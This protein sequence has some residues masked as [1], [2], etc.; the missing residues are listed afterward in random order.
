MT[1]QYL[2]L[3]WRTKRLPMH[4]LKTTD[5]K[6]VRILHIGTYNT[7]SG[8]DF[9]NGKIEIDGLVHSGNIEMHLKSSD[10][11][12]HGHQD[13]EAYNNVIL[14]VVYEYDRLVFIE[15][16]P[17]P[18]VEL[19]ELIDQEHLRRTV[20]LTHAPTVIP[21]AGQLRDCPEPVIWNQVEQALFRRLERK[22]LELTLIAAQVQSDPRKVLFHAIAAAFGMR[23][24][25]LPFQELAHRLPLER[26]IRAGR[27]QVES[28]VFGV[29][30]LLPEEQSDEF[31]L[32]LAREW[33]FQQSKYDLHSAQSHAWQFKG[34]R[35]PG[36]PTIRLAQ[37]SAFVH[38][39]D[40]TESFWELPVS[41]L[42][43]QMEDLLMS[44]PNAYWKNH[45]HFTREKAVI[46]S[47]AMTRAAAQ[48]VIINSV[49]PFLW[50]L[51]GFAGTNIYRE[52]AVEVLELM[53]PEKNVLLDQWKKLELLPKSAA[54]TQGLLEL[55]NEFCDRRQCLQCRIGLSI[56]KR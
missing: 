15:D 47:G 42:R 32:T 37:F 19:R 5:G 54:E 8:P 38:R 56:L 4:L 53:A 23:T 6:P 2:H 20:A 52:K 51:S 48:V 39:M 50:W 55:K 10:W 1:E 14:H 28:M 33:K 3:L 9:F 17:V 35:P 30:G 7:A 16:I 40:W 31:T 34:C 11:Y 22:S 43:K 24:N 44:E 12:A 49:V 25:K 26:L 46:G 41:V 18:T 27:L 13:D 29:S 45:Y 36:F 21:C